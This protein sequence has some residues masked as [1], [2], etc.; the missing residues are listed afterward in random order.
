MRNLILNIVL[1]FALFSC[2]PQP[3][4]AQFEESITLNARVINPRDT[5]NLND[6]L[7]V[8]FEVTDTLLLRGIRIALQFNDNENYIGLYLRK[9][10]K[11]GA[12]NF[13]IV[14]NE[15][16]ATVGNLKSGLVLYFQ[17]FGN[18]LIGEYAFIPKTKGIYF[19]DQQNVG[20]L[21]GNNEQYRIE[22]NANFGNVNRNHKLLLDSITGFAPFLQGHIDQGFEVYGF[23]VK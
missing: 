15:T 2:D 7:K 9:F 3:K 19:I 23:T 18:K 12:G 22:F 17:K 13:R 10:D 11:Q 14:T 20:V 8:R 1:L 16:T 21:Y 4:A 6:T 5:I